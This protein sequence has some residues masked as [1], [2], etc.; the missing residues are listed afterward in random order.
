M[1]TAKLVAEILQMTAKGEWY[2]SW[3]PFDWNGNNICI[4]TE[5]PLH[6]QIK[7]VVGRLSRERALGVVH[8]TFARKKKL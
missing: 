1:S 2:L 5:E 7:D 4:T 3:I 6:P 8:L